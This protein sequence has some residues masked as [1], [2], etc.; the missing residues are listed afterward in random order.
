MIMI[1]KDG[2]PTVYAMACGLDLIAQ[3]KRLDVG[4]PV[5][6]GWRI[7]TGNNESSLIARVAYRDEITEESR[8]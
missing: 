4:L 1:R 5:P 7:L 3:T 8:K 6:D 2:Y